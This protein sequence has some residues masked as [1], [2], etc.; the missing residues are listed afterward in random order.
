MHLQ[1]D[2]RN[3]PY[4]YDKSSDPR[5]KKYKVEMPS[6]PSINL[7]AAPQISSSSS[8]SSTPLTSASNLDSASREDVDHRIPDRLSSKAAAMGISP[9]RHSSTSGGADPYRSLSS[10]STS[11][12]GGGGGE[13]SKSASTR[14][15]VRRLMAIGATIKPKDK[16]L[17]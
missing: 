17:R 10:T 4:P 12:G 14:E 1:T 3:F 15:S 5:C 7:N 13:P 16:L 8:S 2:I 6:L 11:G 9:R